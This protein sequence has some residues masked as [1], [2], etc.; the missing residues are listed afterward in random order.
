MN[1]FVLF[2][3]SPHNNLPS[4]KHHAHFTDEEIRAQKGEMTHSGSHIYL[5][6]FFKPCPV[7]LTLKVLIVQGR[8]W[9][10]KGKVQKQDHQCYS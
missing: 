5:S 9:L 3:F 6:S 7:S 1:F 8:I 4:R 10:V 2:C